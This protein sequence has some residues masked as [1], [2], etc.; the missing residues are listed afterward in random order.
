MSYEAR[1]DSLF[2]VAV[3]ISV[4]V[5]EPNNLSTY[6]DLTYHIRGDSLCRLPNNM[7]RYLSVLYVCTLC[8][9]TV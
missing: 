6:E 2:Q 7:F 8:L 4:S 1:R 9:C 5:V 3:T